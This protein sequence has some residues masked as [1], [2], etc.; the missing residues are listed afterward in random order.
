MQ[1]YISDSQN[2]VSI[3]QNTI[4]IKKLLERQNAFLAQLERTNNSVP[5]L[6]Q[7][8]SGSNCDTFS[9]I[10]NKPFKKFKKLLDFDIAL[11][12]NEAGKKTNGKSSLHFLF[13]AF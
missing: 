11:K 13:L 8:T 6:S 3:L 9:I 10:P 4:A 1:I 7:S 12:T 5:L 2:I